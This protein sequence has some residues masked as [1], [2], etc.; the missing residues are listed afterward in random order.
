MHTFFKHTGIVIISSM[1]INI[2]YVSGKLGIPNNDYEIKILEKQSSENSKHSKHSKHHKKSLLFFVKKKKKSK[3]NK[4]F[5]KKVPICEKKVEYTQTISKS[6]NAYCSFDT[7]NDGIPRIRNCL[8]VA[9]DISARELLL[10]SIK[11]IFEFN[12]RILMLSIAFIFSLI[13]VGI[14]MT[15]KYNKD[16]YRFDK[17]KYGDT[18]FSKMYN[19]LSCS[20]FLSNLR[21]FGNMKEYLK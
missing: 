13:I 21:L 9:I 3:K 6:A 17:V 14:G 8:S 15:I 18:Y 7:D 11:D 12:F 19:F 16:E 1:F 20:L 2:I 10:K 4:S 5:K